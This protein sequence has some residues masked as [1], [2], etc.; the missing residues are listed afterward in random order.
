M[1][2]GLGAGAATGARATAAP[3]PRVR[4]RAADAFEF[5]A[6]VTLVLE[7]FAA[8]GRV[9]DELGA[10]AGVDFG[11]T[12]MSGAPTIDKRGTLLTDLDA[13]KTAEFG[14]PTGFRAGEVVERGAPETIGLAARPM[15]ALGAAGAV[16]FVVL[17]RTAGRSRSSAVAAGSTLAAV[18]VVSSDSVNRS[19]P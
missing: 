13:R 19:T 3:G 8:G 9:P 17:E 7:T 11:V 16:A 12:D 14:A 10:R 4:L 5:R 6:A 2:A 15:V 1:R 18:D